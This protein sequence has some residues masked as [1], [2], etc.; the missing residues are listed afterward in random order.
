MQI[1]LRAGTHAPGAARHELG[2]V[3]NRLG[4]RYDDALLVLSELVTNSV[5]HGPRD[6]EI[7]VDIDIAPDAVHIAVTDGGSWPDPGV[8]RSGRGHGLQIVRS[9]AEDFGV[10]HGGGCTVWVRL[11]LAPPHQP[12]ISP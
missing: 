10:S 12:S 3:R 11:D 8:P 7:G 2:R 5:V 4:P 9:L 6:S 1:T